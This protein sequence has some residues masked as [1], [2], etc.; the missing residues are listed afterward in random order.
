MEDLFVK[1]FGGLISGAV[2]LLGFLF[3]TVSRKADDAFLKA[4]QVEERINQMDS[5]TTRV[6]EMA[7][8][9]AE[10]RTEVKR[11]ERVEGSLSRLEN[12]LIK[13]NG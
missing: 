8:N 11:I 4:S 12:F 7:V 13:T 2:T 5:L 9:V 6:N 1:L 3:R 10:V